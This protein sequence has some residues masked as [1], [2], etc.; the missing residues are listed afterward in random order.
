M[1]F[2]FQDLC[3]PLFCPKNFL[4]INGRCVSLIRNVITKAVGL[5]IEADIKDRE[6][7]ISRL[8]SRPG[9]SDILRS[10]C[11]NLKWTYIGLIALN[12][13]DSNVTNTLRIL[14]I[15][16]YTVEAEI[17][18]TNMISRF[19][20]CAQST[21]DI[22]LNGQWLSV[23]FT[24]PSAQPYGHEEPTTSI[25]MASPGRPPTTYYITKLDFCQQVGA[26]EIKSSLKLTCS[27]YKTFCI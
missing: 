27:T 1:C 7:V 5:A 10:G 21:W 22:H 8:Q 9:V 17:R 14:L 13:F 23:N 12:D 18:F 26:C 24:F 2:L 4:K 20:V 3:L 19:G 25:L 6:M 11:L 15:K 16:I